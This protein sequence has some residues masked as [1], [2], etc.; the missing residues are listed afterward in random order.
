MTATQLEA[1]P[2]T[3]SSEAA[4]LGCAL[5]MPAGAAAK[6]LD[7]LSDSDLVEP[8]FRH[9][10]VAMQRLAG[11][12]ATPDPVLVADEL[13]RTGAA[14]FFRDRTPELVL[15][16]L[17][18]SAPVL[19][20][21]GHYRRLVDDASLRRL[22]D[23]LGTRLKQ[24]VERPDIDRLDLLEAVEQTRTRL[25]G[26]DGTSARG[27]LGGIPLHA[28]NQPPGPLQ[29]LV[30]GR[31]TRSTYTVLGAKPGV[32]KSW[33]AYDLAIA[34]ASG[35]PW[36]GHPIPRPVRV[37]YLDAENGPDLATRRLRQLGARPDDLDD[38]LLFSTEPLLLS[39]SDG[40]ARLRAT[41]EQHKPEL[42]VIDTLA[43][44][45]PGAESDTES[46]AGFLVAVWTLAR[47]HGCALLL[48][49]HL[50]KGLQGSGKDD[51]LDSFRGAGHLIGAADRAWILDPL[52]PGQPR[53]I[54]RDVKPRQFP[55]AAPTRVTV[56]DDEDSPANDRST[57]VV[58][59]G[60][61]AV[62]E[63]GYDAFLAQVLAFIDAHHGRPATT[64]D[65]VHIGMT[66]PG[67]PSER[68]CKDWL[69]RAAAA[70][71]LHKPKRGQWTRAQAALDDQPLDPEE[72]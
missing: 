9:V 68:S 26:S 43:S 24:T 64:K 12:G 32:G 34:L 52:A 55:S 22:V 41:V 10:L 70:G 35:R 30:E 8:R 49:H 7:G 47:Q 16:D 14:K 4:L 59:D 20:S 3:F 63:H 50:R 42:L 25:A 51:P 45:A 38:R 37:L 60:V 69:Q 13:R 57:M 18:Q 2:S 28:L 56:L 72:D 17:M 5:Q 23:E 21:A 71:V 46:M 58:V 40:L 44:H 27:A 29:W 39:T 31:M 53:F 67:E 54:L 19:S 61:E 1:G 65:L 62:I 11:T 36:L 6:A 66:G 33:L 15:H 48:L